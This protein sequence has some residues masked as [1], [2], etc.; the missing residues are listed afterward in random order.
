MGYSSDS[1]S[2]G[3]DDVIDHGILSRGV[4]SQRQRGWQGESMELAHAAATAAQENK[5]SSSAIV[6]L[7]QFRNQDIGQGYQ[8][9]FVVRQRTS[10][11]DKTG[12]HIVDMTKQPREEEGDDKSGR[13]RSKNKRSRRHDDDDDERKES[14]KNI[15]IVNLLQMYLE[16]DGLRQFRRELEKF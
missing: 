15:S 8:A 11:D 10:K 16:C 5:E 12:S 14:K 7:A 9:K 13:R 3:D 2:S 4:I 1:S 6:D